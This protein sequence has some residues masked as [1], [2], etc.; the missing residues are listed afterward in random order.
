M[1]LP[2]LRKDFIIDEWQIYEAKSIG[3]DAILLIVAALSETQLRNYL[4]LAKS[5][6]LQ[7]L[8]ETHDAREVDGALSAGAEVIGVNNRN[9]RNFEV[10]LETSIRLRALVP[11][12]KVFVAESG[13]HTTQ[14]MALL[15]EI[16]CDAALIGESLMTASNRVEKLQLFKGAY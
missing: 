13:I 11:K 3:A 16:G 6:Q 7:T 14:D 5:L 12:D 4:S 1:K 15:K 10:S 2:I 8:V 9:L